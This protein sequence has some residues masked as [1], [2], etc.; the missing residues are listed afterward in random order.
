MYQLLEIESA[1]RV[2]KGNLKS[3]DTKDRQD[4]GLNGQYF[5]A[6]LNQTSI[7]HSRLG[8]VLYLDHLGLFLA[9][10]PLF[11][12]AFTFQLIFVFAGQAEEFIILET[13][14][15]YLLKKCSSCTDSTMLAVHAPV[16]LRTWPKIYHNQGKIGQMYLPCLSLFG[17]LGTCFSSRF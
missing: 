1:C 15:T 11:L 6:Y 10:P 5:T 2:V 9:P 12:G 7:I 16:C 17:T 13:R 14:K 4:Y 8:L 3:T